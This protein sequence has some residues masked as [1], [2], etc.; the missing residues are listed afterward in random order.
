VSEFN[1]RTIVTSILEP[2]KLYVVDPEKRG[3]TVLE[4]DTD[5][6]EIRRMRCHSLSRVNGDQK[7]TRPGTKPE[8]WADLLLYNKE[9]KPIYRI[10]RIQEIFNPT[11]R[12]A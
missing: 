4:I 2:T 7:E 1:K 5:S 10:K 6:G 12:L 9:K 3:H 8:H 11:E